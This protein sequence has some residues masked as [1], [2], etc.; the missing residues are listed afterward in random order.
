MAR[1][2][3]LQSL[4]NDIVD[5]AIAERTLGVCAQITTRIT[6]A[7][8]NQAQPAFSPERLSGFCASA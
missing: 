8:S 6:A 2:S 3:N 5:S 7:N 1:H 4:A